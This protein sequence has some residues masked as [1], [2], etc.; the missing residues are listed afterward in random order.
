MEEFRRAGAEVVVLNRPIGSSAEEAIAIRMIFAWVGLERPRLREV[1]RRP[2][3]TGC[4]TRRG[5][6]QWCSSTTRGMLA[7]TAY[8]GRA[9]Y[10]HSRYLPARLRPRPLRAIRSR[11]PA[12]PRGRRCHVRHG[13]RCPCRLWLTWSR[14]KAAQA[15][16]EASG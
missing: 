16:L 9:V 13:S 5:S 15:Q 6:L 2:Q 14:S 3:H 1:R 8:I 10:G 12:R 7:N 11:R 4:P